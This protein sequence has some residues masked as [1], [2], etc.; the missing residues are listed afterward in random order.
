MYTLSGETGFFIVKVFTLQEIIITLQYTA[1]EM[2]LYF[3]MPTT[4]T[5]NDVGAESVVM[6]TSGHVM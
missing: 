3:N 5:I 1:D 2:S 4:Y 6:K